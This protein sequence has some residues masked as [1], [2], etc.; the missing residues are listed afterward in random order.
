MQIDIRSLGPGD[1][2]AL[3]A[4]GGLF[5]HAPEHSASELSVNER[6]RRQGIRS[7]LV[8]ALGVLARER[9]CYGM[10]TAPR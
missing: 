8:E 4:A 6:S 3:F 1:D 7:A 5:D 2:E 9:D 10:W